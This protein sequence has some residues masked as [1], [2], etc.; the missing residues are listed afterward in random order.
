MAGKNLWPVPR[1]G[2]ATIAT[3]FSLLCFIGLCSPAAN[4]GRDRVYLAN[5]ISKIIFEYG[6]TLNNA[7]KQA[8]LRSGVTNFTDSAVGTQS[9]GSR[10]RF[11][12]DLRE[13]L[14]AQ[15]YVP[16]RAGYFDGY[17]DNLAARLLSAEKLL[18]A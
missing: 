15:P 17:A 1:P 2:K 7:Q 9:N 4:A 14:V 10:R 8:I 16:S 12:R 18:F 13:L 6:V 11:F 3:L 5:D